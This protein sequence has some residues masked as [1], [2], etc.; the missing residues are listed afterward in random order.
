MTRVGDIVH[1][2][3]REAVLRLGTFVDH[4]SKTY[5]YSELFDEEWDYNA[6]WKIRVPGRYDGLPPEGFSSAQLID[7]H[8]RYIGMIHKYH[9]LQG[10]RVVK[11]WK[12]DRIFWPY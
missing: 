5:G 1:I 7:D 4:L 10:D 11:R 6:D 8:N 12:F 9:E 2:D 3:S